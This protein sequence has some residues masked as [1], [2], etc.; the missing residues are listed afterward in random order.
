[1]RVFR[2]IIAKSAFWPLFGAMSLGA[3]ND[4]CFRQAMIAG[5]AFGSL[6]LGSG[7]LADETKSVLGSLAMSLLILPFFLFSSG[8]GELADR[9]RKSSLIKVAKGLELVIMLAAGYF[10]Y[11]GQLIPLLVTIFL[12][13]SQSAFF[14]PLKYGLLPEILSEK[15]L[16]AGNGLISGA[17]FLAIT[18]GS[19]AGS[20]LAGQSSQISLALPLTMIAI[21]AV[22]FGFSLRQPPS[23]PGEPGL[24]VDRRLW[25]STYAILKSVQGRRDIWLP[26]LAISWFWS[27][28]SVILTQ[29][30]VLASSLMGATVG[31]NTFLVTMFSVGVA[32]GSILAQG[33]NRGRVSANLVPLAS[34][35]LTIFMGGLAWSAANLPEAATGSVSLRI[36]LSHW[37][38]LRLALCCFFVSV[39]G[40]LFVVPLNALIQ[41]L[42]PPTERARVIAANNIMN[43]LFI[44]VGSGLVMALVKLGFSLTQVF[45]VVAMSAL[46]VSILSV[47]LLP[48]GP[49][50]VLTGAIIQFLYR[51]EIKG[52]EHLR[53]QEPVL[54]IPNHVSFLDVAILTAF[55]P[56]RL[57]FAIDVNW[58]K[59]WWVRLITHFFETIPINPAAPMTIRELIGAV[60]NGQ[61]LV[62]FPEGSLTRTGTIMKIHH[63]PGLIAAKCQVPV[64]PIIF[65]GLEFTWFGRMRKILHNLPRRYPI[66]MTIFPP[67]FLDA[68]LQPGETRQNFRRRLAETIYDLLIQALFQT[69]DN[70]QNVWNALL[71]AAKN[72]GSG[73]LI[74]EDFN[75]RPFSYARL[76]RSSRVLGRYLAQKTALGEYVGVILPN[77]TPLAAVLFGLWAGGR[78]PVVLNYS[79]GRGHLRSALET[80]VVK[81]LIT[82]R[83]FLKT[84]G[85]SW[86][87]EELSLNVIYLEDLGLSW[88]DKL[89]GLFWAGSPAPAESPAVVV[90]T[91]GSEGRPKGVALSHQ[92]LMANLN[93]AISLVEVNSDDILFNSMPCF[94]AFGL[95]IGLVLPL[96]AGIRSFN[97]I[98]PLRVKAIPELIYDTHATIILGSDSFAAAW[99]RNAHPYDFHTARFVLLGAEKVQARTRDL[100]FQ[101]LG[102]KLF[103]GY[104]ITEGAPVIAVNTPMRAREG[105]VGQFV[106]GLEW[107]L[108]SAPGLKEGGRLL[109]RG[110][111]VMMGYLRSENPGVIEP[112]VDGWHDTGDIVDVDSE[113][114]VWIKGRFKRFAK[115]SGEMISLA[116]I[117]EIAAQVW[118]G[119]RLAVISQPDER[120]GE[121]L[122]LVSQSPG[123]E[124]DHLRQ[125]IRAR[126]L[127][128][129]S[130]PRQALRVQEIPLT[131][132]GKVNIP[133]LTEMAVATLTNPI[134]P[135]QVAPRPAPTGAL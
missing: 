26:I 11:A 28:G 67:R 109:V 68:E 116:L 93:Q 27:M 29:L 39:A 117:E 82:S 87:L 58:S 95:N 14:G 56:R 130:C 46:A 78:V 90:F 100:Y 85:Q 126:G 47:Y 75:R 37:P 129:L 102:V 119:E 103:E 63:G 91:S 33:L 20:L 50:V 54:I 7:E 96:L 105:S 80:A 21:S 71:V 99:A 8:A 60:K 94:H 30:P 81:T 83:N 40:G 133:L 111:N 41:H 69:R 43:S 18:L 25:R 48:Q 77:T 9:E 97:F 3:F 53:G 107:R 72:H 10:F 118:P 31:V 79:Q 57:A 120:K 131:P 61:T 6:S 124:L 125:A 4:N 112:L 135:N 35:F 122:I 59:V 32:L 66:S 52:L 23:L 45:L 132:L 17:S 88:A 127:T 108:E 62:I 51:P 106:P 89:L 65:Q 92:N 115:I 110:P 134:A 64:V 114:F 19:I 121:R 104:G 16:L 55:L 22:G 101:R 84:V 70:R 98:S 76:I 42:A 5:L 36:F 123:L 34:I 38:Y 74:L 15:E 13:G 12:M 24:Q 73:R 128:D 1:M 44:V 49:L 86:G 2:A 113:G